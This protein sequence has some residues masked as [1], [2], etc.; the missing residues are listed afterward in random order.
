MRTPDFDVDAS[1]VE[2]ALEL[3]FAV[4]NSYPGEL[5]CP[6]DYAEAVAAYRARRFRSLSVG[7]LVRVRGEGV[8]ITF[9][10]AT[11]GWSPADPPAEPPEVE[12]AADGAPGAGDDTRPS[13]P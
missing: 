2:D 11:L 8:D 1:S 3:A 9:R 6:A 5:V 12:D 10:C 4:C 7:D 13:E